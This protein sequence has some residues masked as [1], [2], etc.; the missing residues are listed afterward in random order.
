MTSKFIWS[1][2]KWKKKKKSGPLFQRIQPNGIVGSQD[3]YF[4]RYKR[5][6]VYIKIDQAIALKRFIREQ[7]LA[8]VESKQTKKKKVW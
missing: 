8:Y 7:G 5:K 6:I 1:I 4:K 2:K 3:N